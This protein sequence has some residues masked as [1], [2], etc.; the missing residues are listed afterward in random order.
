MV[1]VTSY[2]WLSALQ[3][4]VGNQFLILHLTPFCSDFFTESLS[5]SLA[6]P[7]FSR[8]SVMPHFRDCC[9]SAHSWAGRDRRDH[10]EESQ[11]CWKQTTF[12]GARGTNE[13]QLRTDAITHD[14]D[15]FQDLL[16]R[17]FCQ[18]PPNSLPVVRNKYQ[19]PKNSPK[20]SKS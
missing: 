3:F 4:P 15:N 14:P 11:N 18:R 12:S 9:L 20:N 5:S 1:A 10:V 8:P 13:Q 2:L 17:S 16:Q 6:R 19:S 7:R